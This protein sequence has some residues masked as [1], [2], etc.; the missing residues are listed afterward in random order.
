MRQ[1]GA[2]EQQVR[3]I[4]VVDRRE[5]VHGVE[6]DG[7]AQPGPDR[8]RGQ[9]IPG[10]QGLSRQRE[11]AVDAQNLPDPTVGQQRDAPRP[12]SATEL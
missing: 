2:A 8:R 10:R 11:D 9:I 3:G 6:I 4:R 7:L 12:V 1:A 5:Q